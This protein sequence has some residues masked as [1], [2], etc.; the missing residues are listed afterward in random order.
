LI[1]N[2][3]IHRDYFINSVVKVFIFPNR[4]EIISPGK[5][6]NSLTVENILNGISIPRNPTL[7]SIAQIILP[8]SGLGT[9]LIRIN[10]LYDGIQFKNNITNEVFT[11]T[12]KRR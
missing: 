6:P 8:Y 3:L 1:V 4:I 10:R 5:L 11:V 9:G 12:I 7:Q 2:A